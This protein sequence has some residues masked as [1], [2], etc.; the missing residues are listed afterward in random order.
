MRG[1]LWSHACSH[2]AARGSRK[3]T[4]NTPKHGWIGDKLHR[5]RERDRDRKSQT[6]PLELS[7]LRAFNGDLLWLGMQCLQHVVGA[8]VTVD[9]TNAASQSG[10]DR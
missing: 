5:I 3:P 8:C 7:Q 6:P 9:G 4:T 10:H 2:N 1:E